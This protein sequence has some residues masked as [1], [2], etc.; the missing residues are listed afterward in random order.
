MKTSKRDGWGFESPEPFDV[1]VQTDVRHTFKIKLFGPIEEASQF[2]YAIEAFERAT[3]TDRV[4]VHLS[5]P[6]GNVDA[7]DTFLSAMSNCAAPVHIMASGGCH[8]AATIIL[9]NAPSFTLSDNFNALIHNGSTGSYGKASDF[10][11][12]SRFT[13]DFMDNLMRKTY[14]GFLSEDEIEQ[15]LNGK[16]FW[17]GPQEFC[18]RYERRSELLNEGSSSALEEL[19][20]AKAQLEDLITK[21]KAEGLAED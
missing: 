2:N 15:L 11:A 1:T 10:K 18:D 3:E 4:L 8:S 21:V 17:M 16:D 13:T 14:E 7:T 9:L 12:E 5:S 6:G 20:A 19:E